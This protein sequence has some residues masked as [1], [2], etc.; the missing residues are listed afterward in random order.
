[1]KISR[2][3]SLFPSP[4]PVRRRL[5]RSKPLYIATEFKCY[6]TGEGHKEV[7]RM[8]IN[9]SKLTGLVVMIVVGLA[10]FGIINTVVSDYTAKD[11]V[12]GAPVTAGMTNATCT[13][14]DLVPFLVI[15]G[16]VV[17][18]VYIALPKGSE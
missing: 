5:W 6:D 12:T 11:A 7:S 4:V 13:M 9:A 10:F 14:L 1:M 8:P 3:N 15:I 2:T 17:G 18:A 16:L